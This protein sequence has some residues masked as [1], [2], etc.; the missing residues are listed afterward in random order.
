MDPFE[1]RTSSAA[2]VLD[3]FPRRLG[4]GAAVGL[5]G[6]T[7]RDRAGRQH[8]F[9]RESEEPQGVLVEIDEAPRLLAEDDEG[10]G[11]VLDNRPISGLAF[12]DPP[13]LPPPQPQVPAAI[14]YKSV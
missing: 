11:R 1:D 9:P 6:R 12:L 4:R 8:L 5:Q 13:F 10:F 7:Q 14:D 2:G 3:L